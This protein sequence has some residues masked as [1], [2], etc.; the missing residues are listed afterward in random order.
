MDYT[1]CISDNSELYSFGFYDR[2]SYGEIN[3]NY[4]SKIFLL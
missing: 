1:M 4:S 2:E 3:V